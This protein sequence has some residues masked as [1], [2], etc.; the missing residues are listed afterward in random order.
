MEGRR[1]RKASAIFE[2]SLEPF[3]HPVGLVAGLPTAVGRHAFLHKR[4]GA[5]TEFDVTRSVALPVAANRRRG[6]FVFDVIVAKR[7][8]VSGLSV[9]AAAN[10]EILGEFGRR[11]GGRRDGE[12]ELTE[13]G[14]IWRRV[15]LLLSEVT[16]KAACK[17]I[18]VYI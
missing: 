9:R 7:R 10:R 18:N 5:E 15:Y 11:T 17:S 14:R 3:H 2:T 8:H 6:V 4:L 16:I 13:T 1:R 12:M